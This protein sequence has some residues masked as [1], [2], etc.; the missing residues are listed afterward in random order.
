MN[1][2]QSN[3]PID[4]KNSSFGRPQGSQYTPAGP[5][6]YNSSNQQKPTN[7]RSRVPGGDWGDDDNDN[8][9]PTVTSNTQDKPKAGF[10]FLKKDQ[11]KKEQVAIE[12]KAQDMY[13]LID[14]QDLENDQYDYHKQIIVGVIQPAG[15][16]LKPSEAIL[17]NMDQKC[18]QLEVSAIS[19]LLYNAGSKND[20][21][22]KSRI[23]ACYA[24]E[25]LMTK[26]EKYWRFFKTN[27]I[28]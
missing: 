15:V 21:H 1:F 8:V 9:V 5:M 23:R 26:R 14:P 7:R 18:D 2:P 4:T 6:Y 22:W 20:I 19:S 13:Q 28:H 24:I 27:S 25:Y 17:S 11:E 16:L 3:K 10:G 12:K